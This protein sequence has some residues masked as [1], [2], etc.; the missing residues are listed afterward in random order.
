MSGNTLAFAEFDVVSW[1][2]RPA[3]WS[4]DTLG[5]GAFILLKLRYRLEAETYGRI[6]LSDGRVL[7][8]M[9][10]ALAVGEGEPRT[11]NGK[12][13]EGGCGLLSVYGQP[14]GWVTLPS[15]SMTR[16][17]DVFAQWPGT[18]YELRVTLGL[19]PMRVDDRGRWRW[20]V[21]GDPSLKIASFEP[22][23]STA[24]WFDD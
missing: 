24:S 20:D 22:T 10:T 14:G 16:L 1:Q 5:S 23:A 19:T 15:Q 2:L 3:N 12:L 17:W 11:G 21:K 4:N 6:G 13:V 7:S 9:V 8:D 18:R